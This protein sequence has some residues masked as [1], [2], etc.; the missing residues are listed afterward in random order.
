MSRASA[1]SSSVPAR[2]SIT[3]VTPPGGWGSTPLR[4]PAPACTGSRRGGSGRAPPGSPRSPPARR[5]ATARRSA[6]R[7][8]DR[9]WSTAA[10]RVAPGDHEAGGHPHLGVEGVDGRLQALHHRRRQQAHPGLQPRALS[11]GPWPVRPRPRTGRA[12]P[13]GCSRPWARRP[14]PGP[15]RGP[16]RPRPRPRRLRDRS[17][18]WPPGPRRGGRWCRR[19]RPGCRSSR[20][21]IV[22][23]RGSPGRR[24]E[25]PGDG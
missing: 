21:A 25:G 24:G 22:R 16:R 18:P 19:R 4:P 3:V 6:R 14:P 9:A 15:P 20:G 2:N 10:A 12:A 23:L 17:G 8:T 5:W 7:T 13:R 11:P 1:A